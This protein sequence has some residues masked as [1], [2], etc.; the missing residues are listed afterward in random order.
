MKN[1][2][3]SLGHYLRLK[4]TFGPSKAGLLCHNFENI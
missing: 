3:T 1:E 4:K 2:E